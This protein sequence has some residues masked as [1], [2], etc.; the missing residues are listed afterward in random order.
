M[1]DA[2]KKNGVAATGGQGGVGFFAF[3]D[4]D[5]A[6]VALFDFR[7]ELADFLGIDFGGDDLPG[8]ADVAR[9]GEGKAP[10][11]GADIGNHR[12]FLPLHECGEAIDFGDR[13]GMGEGS[14]GKG[15]GEKQCSDG[16][17]RSS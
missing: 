6:E 5:I 10:I 9:G 13:I 1:V 7:A 17:R 11:A 14:N 2:T 8:F 15:N 16:G 12:A 4:Q 3:F